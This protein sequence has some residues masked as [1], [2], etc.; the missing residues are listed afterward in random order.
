MR[1]QGPRALPRQKMRRPQPYSLPGSR[2]RGR[3]GVDSASCNWPPCSRPA[4]PHNT[5]SHRQLC[6]A[7]CQAPSPPPH[8][9]TQPH[10]TGPRAAARRS[11]IT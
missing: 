11:R 8:T 5:A 9:F 3:S 1:S 2:S 10:A 4:R 6:N 7:D